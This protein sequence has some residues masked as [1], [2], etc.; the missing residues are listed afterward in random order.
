MLLPLAR[1]AAVWTGLRVR[2]KAC[3]E[4]VL[5]GSLSRPAT[6]GADATGGKA[7]ASQVAELSVRRLSA[8]CTCEPVGARIRS[9]GRAVR[10]VGW[11]LRNGWGRF[12]IKRGALGRGCG[13]EGSGALPLPRAAVISTRLRVPLDLDA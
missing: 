11:R 13:R 3:R 5:W 12:R 6:S 2:S 7:R 4:G 9:L 1:A 10:P 8:S